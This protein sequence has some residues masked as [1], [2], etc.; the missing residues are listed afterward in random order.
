MLADTSTL[1]NLT[2]YAKNNFLSS[3]KHTVDLHDNQSVIQ[4]SIEF[5]DECYTAGI[6][7]SNMGYY[8]KLGLT[9]Q[10]VNNA[11][12]GKS[13]SKI[14]PEC[15]DTLKKV[16]LILSDYREQL[17]VTGKINPVT[18]IFWSKNFDGMTDV[19]KLEVS[20]D[21]RITAQLPPDEIQK[22]I[23]QDIPIDVDGIEL[24]DNE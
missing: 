18:A 22:R 7:P 13:K 19:T 15:I 9:R 24:S 11:L 2:Q 8:R 20:S 21:N 5:F 4:A 3:L 10:D 17:A 23:E 1:Q 14:S 12:T 16:L 6:R